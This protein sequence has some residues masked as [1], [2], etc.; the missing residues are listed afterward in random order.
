M[1][2]K[3]VCEEILYCVTPTELGEL[4]FATS[5][6]GLVLATYD[7]IDSKQPEATVTNCLRRSFP[8]AKFQPYT[9]QTSA[10][11]SHLHSAQRAL[12]AYFLGDPAAL[13]TVEIAP[14]G[15]AFQK[16]V[17]QALRTIPF[18]TTQSYSALA[19]SAGRPKAIRAAGTAC[20]TNP[21]ILFVPCHRVIGKDGALTGFA[22]GLDKK[23]YLLQH[24]STQA[25]HGS[26][27]TK[28]PQGPD[29]TAA[30]AQG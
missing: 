12:N 17:W 5:E 19:G 14:H 8:K 3:P 15:T 28:R 4:L 26:S 22:A 1:I 20:K 2:Q 24:E 6:Q 11:A 16:D 7:E 27:R 29:A 25:R 13:D 10:A 9:Q 21:L 23:A 18:G 30:Q